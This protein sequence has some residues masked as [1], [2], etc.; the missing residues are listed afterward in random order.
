MSKPK[1]KKKRVNLNLL[2]CSQCGSKKVSM[3]AWVNVNTNRYV[4]DMGTD[5]QCYCE[6]CECR[7]TPISLKEYNKLQK[8]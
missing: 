1:K 8:L 3:E 4:D 7:L 6:D 5:A 2:V